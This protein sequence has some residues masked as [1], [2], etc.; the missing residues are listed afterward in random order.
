M[1]T[2]V[3]IAVSLE[4]EKIR[5][6]FPTSTVYIHFIFYL[7]PVVLRRGMSGSCCMCCAML[8]FLC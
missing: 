3:R 8:I 7:I 2:K 1:E 5:D 4:E 6:S